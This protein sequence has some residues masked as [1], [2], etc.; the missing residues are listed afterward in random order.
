MPLEPERRAALRPVL[1]EEAAE[2]L[3][4]EAYVFGYP[5]VLMD[6]TRQVETAVPRPNGVK[7]PMNRFVHG[8]REPAGPSSAVRLPIVDML[9]SRA[10]LTLAKEP[11]VLSVPLMGRRYY[12]MQLHDAWTN[13]FA[14][15][16]TRTT[17][18]ADRDFLIVGPG[19]RGRMPHGVT[20]LSCPTSMAL[21]IGWTRFDG[22]G[23]RDSARGTQ[24][25]YGLVPMSA[26]GLPYAAVDRVP[27][28]FGVDLDTP[29]LE[30]VARMDAATFFGRL[31]LLMQDNPPA[32]VDG[33]L[34]RRLAALG[35][36]RGLAFNLADQ[37]SP[38]AK[39]IARSVRTG[40][41]MIVNEAK[42]P[43]GKSV[44]GWMVETRLGRYGSNYLLRAV[45]T[46]MHLGAGLPEDTLSA[47]ATVDGS[48]RPLSGAHRYTIRFEQ[49]QLPPVEGSWA[50]TMYNVRQ[51]IVENAL[52]RHALHDRDRLEVGFDGSMTIYLQHERPDGPEPIANWLPAPTGGFTV[53]LRLHW[54]RQEALDGTWYPPPVVRTT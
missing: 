36:G 31:A 5:L 4:A 23:E 42:K 28:E 29:P 19:W 11:L 12:V 21:A 50:I 24:A 1:S 54:P 16:G 40:M 6:V 25:E 2:A 35:I 7:A 37:P 34:M 15:P 53:I 44:N 38:T 8:G 17:G 13:V 30:Q 18:N 9:P 47:A 20:P 32:D 10:W 49:G 33:P 41:E 39:A 26:L 52:G 45:S 51:T 22:A 43:P 48:E 46:M 27:V 3:A 14:A